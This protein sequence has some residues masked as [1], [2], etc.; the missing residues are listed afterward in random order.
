MLLRR[1]E[2][3]RHDELSVR[4]PFLCYVF[5]LFLFVPI[6]RRVWLNYTVLALFEV[7]FRATQ[8]WPSAAPRRRA[9]A[10]RPGA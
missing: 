4:A 10:A 8:T 6:F 1:L 5:A 7:P 9:P 3:P 2:L